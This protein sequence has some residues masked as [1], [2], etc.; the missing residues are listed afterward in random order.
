MTVAVNKGEV[1]MPREAGFLARKFTASH[2]GSEHGI[3][4][5]TQYMYAP[6]CNNYSLKPTH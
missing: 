2:D 4:H 5:K 1:V 3:V 6:R